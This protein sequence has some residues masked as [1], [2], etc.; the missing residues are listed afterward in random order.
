MGWKVKG[1]KNK[2]PRVNSTRFWSLKVEDRSGK[3]VEFC[4][5]FDSERFRV[6]GWVNAVPNVVVTG[7]E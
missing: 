3:E 6:I 2:V 4:T 5:E 1:A 7:I